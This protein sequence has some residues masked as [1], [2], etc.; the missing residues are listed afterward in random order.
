MA[1][2][3]V[4]LPP[5]ASDLQEY[6]FPF[7]SGSWA[8]RSLPD[9]TV[10]PLSLNGMCDTSKSPYERAAALVGELTLE[11]KVNS[12]IFYIP[13]IERLNTPPFVIRC[14]MLWNEAIHGV[15]SGLGTNFNEVG[16]FSHAISFTLPILTAAAF[17]DE[18]IYSIANAIGNEVCAC[19]SAGR[20]GLD[21]WIPNVKTWVRPFGSGH[22]WALGRTFCPS[23]HGPCPGLN[24]LNPAEP[25]DNPLKTQ[26][27]P[28]PA[29]FLPFG[30]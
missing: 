4:L 10:P 30:P 2:G 20:A 14:H 3:N 17:D 8:I 28:F 6:L 25:I 16:D 18:L 5:V 7:A 1:T 27:N 29:Q 24:P 15:A 23:A 21:V 26:A 13:A 9:C 12:S 11:E 22:V 19:G